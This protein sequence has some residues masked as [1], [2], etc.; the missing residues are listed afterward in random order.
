MLWLYAL[1]TVA[2]TALWVYAFCDALTSPGSEV[3]NLPKLLWLIL[4]AV[5]MHVGA[6]LWLF[7][8]RPRETAAVAAEEPSGPTPRQQPPT[9]NLSPE[10]FSRPRGAQNPVGPDDDPE[11]LRKLNKRINPDE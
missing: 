10:D 11:F 4:I 5:F 8:G 6:L 3:R 1:L 2:F 9:Q 7:F